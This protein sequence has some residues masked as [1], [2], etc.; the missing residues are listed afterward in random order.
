MSDIKG[1]KNKATQSGSLDPL[2][3]IFEQHLYNFQDSNVDRKTFIAQVVQTYLTHL[4]KMKI[5]VPKPY[6][7]YII[8][9]LA[10]MVNS[11]LVKKIYGCISISEFRQKRT[12]SR[13]RKT[14]SKPTRLRTG[15]N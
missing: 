5:T 1:A 13:T 2:Y 10:V 6:E 7:P 3:S 12:G 11:M 8:E 15:S 9:E 14:G 4:R